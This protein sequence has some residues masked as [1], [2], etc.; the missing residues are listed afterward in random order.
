MKKKKVVI[1]A[2]MFAFLTAT[3][4]LASVAVAAGGV[5]VEAVVEA[6]AQN[7]EV[8]PGDV[9]ATQDMEIKGEM[10]KS[11]TPSLG[12]WQR[13]WNF[14]R[15]VIE[16]IRAWKT[17]MDAKKID[18]SQKNEDRRYNREERKELEKEN[19]Q[20]EVKEDNDSL[21]NRPLVR[22][23]Q[24]TIITLADNHRTLT[25]AVGDR[26]SLNLGEGFDWE[27][28][29]DTTGPVS[30]V[31]NLMLMRGVQGVYSADRPGT[32]QF[33]ALGNPVCLRS[34]PA[35][36][37]ASISFVLDVVVKGVKNTPEVCADVYQ[38]VC[39]TIEVQCIRAPCP[40]LKETFPNRCV[41]EARKATAITEGKCPE[42]AIENKVQLNTGIKGEINTMIK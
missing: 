25:L 39:G 15:A 16:K 21:K 17:R 3:C 20:K 6:Q 10:S 42:P 31:K 2:I 26:F 13:V 9:R 5:E 19:E 8:L 32:V 7:R 23:G 1:F 24:N 22:R 12:F 30:R 11:A 38:P 4:G 18:T 40:P 29:F 36:A 33:T 14:P 41:A 34:N 35:C 28:N 27:I 37:M